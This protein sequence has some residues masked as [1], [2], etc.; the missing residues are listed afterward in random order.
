MRTI[1]AVSLDQKPLFIDLDRT[2]MKDGRVG[3]RTQEDNVT[4]FDP[5]A[6]R[7][8]RPKEVH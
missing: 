1:F 5:I 4:R 6:I 2:R 7:A 8:L 3:F